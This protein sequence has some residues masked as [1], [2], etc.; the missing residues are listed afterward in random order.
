D[1]ANLRGLVVLALLLQELLEQRSVVEV[2][3]YRVLALAGDDDDVLDAGDDALLGDILNLRLIHDREHFLRLGFGRGQETGAQ[4]RGRKDRL[5]DFA[6]CVVCGTHHFFFTDF[7]SS[8]FLVSLVALSLAV[9]S[10]APLL[11]GSAEVAPAPES[12]SDLADFAA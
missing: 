6:S 3:L 10:L 8:D 1:A 12:E 4:T 2:I 7:F 5:A 11:P 9:E